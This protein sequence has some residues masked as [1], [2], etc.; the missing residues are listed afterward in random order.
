MEFL[1]LGDLLLLVAL[2]FA[3]LI[4][5]FESAERRRES[6][7]ERTLLEAIEAE[8]RAYSRMGLL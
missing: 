6:K 7:R 8:Y 5:V 1:D 3:T 2:L 4:V